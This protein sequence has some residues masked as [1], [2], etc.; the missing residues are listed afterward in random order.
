VAQDHKFLSYGSKGFVFSDL[1][2]DYLMNMEFRGQFRLSYPTDDDRVTMDDYKD[3]QVKL[4]NLNY[5][6]SA[7]MSTGRGSKENDDKHLMYP[8]KQ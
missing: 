6:I 1:S 2:G 4:L 5:W 3:E 7:F 8:S